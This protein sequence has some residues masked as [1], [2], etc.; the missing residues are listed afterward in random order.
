[1]ASSILLRF[2]TVSFSHRVGN[3]LFV[4]IFCVLLDTPLLEAFY[5]ELPKNYALSDLCFLANSSNT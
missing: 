3:I 4:N 5:E 1:M 2:R